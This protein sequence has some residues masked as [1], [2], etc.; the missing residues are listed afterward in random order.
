MITYPIDKFKIGYC[1][2]STIYD[3]LI[4]L[5]ALPTERGWYIVLEYILSFIIS[6]TA[7]VSGYFICKWLDRD[8]HD[9]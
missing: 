2:K 5:S 9:N 8:K 1:Q 7:E 3:I 4:S 6:V